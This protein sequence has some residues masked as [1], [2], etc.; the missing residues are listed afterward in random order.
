VRVACE[1]FKQTTVSFQL[2]QYFCVQIC[3]FYWCSIIGS[4]SSSCWKI[5]QRSFHWHPQDGSTNHWKHVF[6]D[7]RKSTSYFV[8]LWVYWRNQH[9]G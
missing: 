6:T 7:W 3:S 8:S 9:Q 5:I 2:I 1:L 4:H